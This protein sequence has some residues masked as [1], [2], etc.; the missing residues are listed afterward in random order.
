MLAQEA[1]QYDLSQ[2]ADRAGTDKQEIIHLAEELTSHGRK[3]V[4]DFF[5]GAVMHTNGVYTG[6]ALMTL[7]MLMG[8]IDWMG[9]YMV[10][11]GAANILGTSTGQPYD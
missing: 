8:N 4:V 11:G 7:N 9:G 1:A 10:G 6:R 3:A 5:R 2:Y